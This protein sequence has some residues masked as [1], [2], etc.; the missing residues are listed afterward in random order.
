[1]ANDQEEINLP[2]DNNNDRKTSLDLL[3]KYFRT[4]ANKKFL[5]ATLD[6]LIQDGVID[7]VN[8]YLGRKTAKAF[9]PSDNYISDITDDRQNYQLEPA[10]VVKDNNNNTTFYKDYNDYINQLTAFGANTK[11]H[12]RLN[13]QE[14]YSWDP[15]V[16]WDKLTNYREYYWLS[17]GPVTISISGQEKGITSTYTVQL[18]NDGDSN[19]YVFNPDGLTRNPTL[20]LYRGQTYNFEIDQENNPFFIKTKKTKTGFEYNEKVTN[21]GIEKGTVSIT[22]DQNT[23]DILYY[24]NTN[25]M[26]ATGVI[27]VLSI[28]ENTKIDVTQEIIGKKTYQLKSG[29]YLSNGMKVDFLGDV[30]PEIYA[31]GNWYVE[32]VGKEIILV[33]EQEL[34]TRFPNQ[35][36]EELQFDDVGFDTT[37]FDQSSEKDK[38]YITINRSAYD[39]NQWSRSNRWFHKEV[40][41]TSFEI[42]GLSPVIDQSARANRPIIEFVPGL[43]LFNNGWNRIGDV[44]LVDTV[45]TNIMSEI[46]GTTGYYIDNINLVEG[47]RIIFTA[48]D[49]LLVR[50]KIYKV[51]F[52][53]FNNERIITLIP[54]ETVASEGD[55]VVVKTGKTNQGKQF[56]YSDN[57]WKESQ[58][59]TTENQPPMFDLYDNDGISL[60]DGTVYGSTEFAGNTVFS[61]RQGNGT[62]DSVLGFPITYLNVSNIGDIVFDCNLLTDTYSYIINER[63]FSIIAKDA[64][65]KVWNRVGNFGYHSAWERAIE[66]STQPVIRHY[67]ADLTR[68]NFEI[69]VYNNAA[70]LSDLSVQVFLNNKI[71]YD[72]QLEKIDTRLYLN[73]TQ[74]LQENDSLI[75]KTHTK[76][77]N[78]TSKGYYE[79]PLNLQNNPTNKDPE[80]ITLGEIIDHVESIVNDNPDVTGN[81]PGVTNLRD[82]GTASKYGKRFV[83]HSGPV[84]IALYHL[85]NKSTNIIKAL[86][87]AAKDYD[88]F[89][90]SYI[91]YITNNSVDS[92][93]PVAVD[94]VLLELLNGKSEI[95]YNSG[96]VP[97]RAFTEIEHTIIDNTFELY[98]IT[99]A[100][101]PYLHQDKAILVYINDEQ[102][103]FEKDYEFINDN[104]VKITKEKQPGDKIVIREYDTVVGSYIPPTPAKLGLLPKYRPMKYL[105]TTLQTPVNVIQ[106]HDGSVIRAFD[107]YRDDLILELERRIYNNIK[108]EYTNDLIDF[109]DFNPSAYRQTDY[110]LKEVNDILRPLFLKWHKN[111]NVS[112]N[113]NSWF[114]TGNPWTYNYSTGNYNG[115]DL[116]G[117]WRG[118]YNHW[119]DTDRPHISPWEMLGFSTEPTW[120]QDTYGPAPYTSENLILWRDLE[121]GRIKEPGAERINNKFKRPGLTSVIPVDQNGNLKDPIATNIAQEYDTLSFTNDFIFGDYAPVENAWRR[122]SGYRFSLLCA[123]FLTKPAQVFGVYLDRAHTNRDVSGIIKY[124]GEFAT[125][126]GLSDKVSNTML[127]SGLIDYVNNWLYQSGSSFIDE[128]IFNLE[129][130]SNQLGAKL[131]G[132][133]EKQKFRLILDSRTPLNEGNV[134]VPDENYEVILNTSSPVEVLSYSGVIIEKQSN[135]FIIKGYDQKFPFF[136]YRPVITSN[137][138]T[139]I[140]IGAVSESFIS[141]AEEKTYIQGKIVNYNGLYYRCKED[142]TSTTTFDATKFVKLTELPTIGG[143]KFF[144]RSSYD[145]DYATLDYGTTLKTVQDV[146]DFLYGYSKY[147]EDAGF[148]FDEYDNENQILQDWDTSVKEFVFWTTQ[149]WA[150]GTVIALSPGAGKFSVNIEYTNV[151]DLLNDFYDYEIYNSSGTRININDL[152]VSRANSKFSLSSNAE[153]GIYFARMHLVQTEHVLLID[154]KTVF[155]DIIYDTPAGY[156]QERVKVLGYKT[157]LWDG[158]L[159]TPGFVYD[160]IVINN[161]EPF[162]QYQVGDIVKNKE[163]LYSAKKKVVS[164]EYFD[165]SN[166][167]QL[168]GVQKSQL[169]PNFDYRAEQFTDFFDLDTDN[170]DSEQQ[171][172]AQHTIGYQKRRYLENIINDDVSQYKFYQGMI[173]DKGTKNV[174]NKMFD[175]LSSA[176]QESLEFYEEWAIRV[177]QYGAVDSFVEVEYLIDEKNVRLDPQ[178][179]E[180]VELKDSSATDLVYRYTNDEAYVTYDGYTNTPF[181]A[182]TKLPDFIRTAGNVDESDVT[183]GV[184]EVDDILKLNIDDFKVGSTVWVS[185]YGT[186]WN[187][188]RMQESGANVLAINPVGKDVNVT[189]NN[190]I[191]IS[192]GDIVAIKNVSDEA[193][194]FY[195]I[196]AI[197]GYTVTLETDKKLDNAI[198]M[199]DSSLGIFYNFVDARIKDVGELNNITP[200]A[201]FEDGELIWVDG[202]DGNWTVYEKNKVYNTTELLNRTQ[203]STSGTFGKSLAVDEYNRDFI[204]G[205]PSLIVSAPVPVIINGVIEK[206]ESKSE[207]A[208]YV[209][210][211][212]NDITD[213]RLIQTITLPD[214]L[215]VIE[216]DIGL[217]ALLERPLFTGFGQVISTS[218]DTRFM[219]VGVPNASDIPSDFLGTWSAITVYSSDDVVEYNGAFYKA[220]EDGLFATTPDLVDDWVRVGYNPI[221]GQAISSSGL[222]DQGFVSVYVRT[223]SGNFTNLF[224]MQSPEPQAGQRFGETIRIEKV[225]SNDYRMFVAAPNHDGIGKIFVFDWNLGTGGAWTYNPS[226]NLPA[227]VRSTGAERI[228]V[229]STNM[230]YG[231]AIN[232][233]NLGNTLLVSAPY[234]NGVHFEDY[235]GNYDAAV[236]YAVDSVVFYNSNYWKKLTTSAAGTTPVAGAD[237]SQ[238]T[239]D[240]QGQYGKLYVYSYTNSTYNLVEVISEVNLNNANP[241]SGDKFAHSVDVTTDGSTLA[242]G[243]PNYDG[244]GNDSGKVLVLAYNGTSYE[245]EQ[246]LTGNAVDNQEFGYKVSISGDTLAIGSRR[247]DQIDR[248]TILPEGTTFDSDATYLS[249]IYVDTGK[250]DVYSK[251][252]NVFTYEDT[253]ILADRDLY[254]LGSVLIANRNHVIVGVPNYNDYA[255]GVIDFW[256]P[257]NVSSWKVHRQAVYP[258]DVT[259]VKS[260]FLYD[261]RKNV[262]VKQLDVIDPLQGKIA[263]PADQE[264]DYKTFWD[265]AI[266][267]VGTEEVNVD[268]TESWDATSVGKVWWDLDTARF[269]NYHQNSALYRANNWSKLSEY[270]DIDV[271]EWVSSKYKPSQWDSLADSDNGLSLGVSGKT[272]YGDNAY[273]VAKEYD[274]V[275]KNFTSKYMFWVKQKTTVPAVENRKLSVAAIS[276]L[277]ANPSSQGYAHI[278]I[279]SDNSFVLY[280]CKQFLNDNDIA[281]NIRFWNTD[282]IDS[283]IHKQYQIL[284]EG[285]GISTPNDTIINKWFDSL[286]GFTPEGLVVPNPNLSEQQRYGILNKPRQG[287]FKN[288]AEAFKQFIEYVNYVFNK[289]ILVDDFDLAPFF[290]KEQ[291]PNE[292]SRLYDLQ[293]EDDL[294]LNFIATGKLQPAAID[295][296]IEDGRV[297]D[298]IITDAGRGYIT[299]PLI[300]VVGQGS[301]AVLEANLDAFGRISTVDIKTSG[302]GYLDDTYASVRQYTVLSTNVNNSGNWGLYNY[303]TASKTWQ[304]I[305]MQSYDVSKYWTYKDW[306]A[307]GFNESTPIDYL[308]EG[309]FQL[310]NISPRTN[311]LVKITN[312]GSSGEW[313]LL[314]RNNQSNE[315]DINLN[316][317]VVG[318]QSATIEISSALYNFNENVLGYDGISYEEIPYDSIP[319]TEA[320]IILEAIRSNVFIDNLKVEFN[321]LFFNSIRY[322]LTEQLSV[323][324]IFKT[325]FV[326]AKHNVGEL[327]QRVTY[328]N[329]SLSSYQDYVNEVKP[330]RTKVRE[331][332]SS[333]TKTETVNTLTSDFDLRAN[334]N[335]KVIDNQLLLDNTTTLDVYPDKSWKDN[336]SYGVT[337]IAIQDAGLGYQTAPELTIIGG[338]GTGATARAFIGRGGSLSTIQITNPGTGYYSAPQIIING[339][340]DDTGRAATLVA[341]IDNGTTRKNK[342]TVK[343]DRI[344]GTTELTTLDVTETFIGTGL[345]TDFNLK[346]PVDVRKGFTTVTVN[347]VEL[348]ES[349]FTV[350][351]VT[352]YNDFTSKAGHL[353]IISPPDATQ[354][355]VVEYKKDIEFLR[356]SDRINYYYNPVSGQRSS[357]LSGLLTGI[358]YGGTS[359]T[360]F[361]FEP[362]GGWGTDGTSWDQVNWEGN[363]ASFTDITLYSS[364]ADLTYTFEEAPAESETWNVYLNGVRIDDPNFGTPAEVANS[365]AIMQSIIGDGTATDFVIPVSLAPSLILGGS[366]QEQII[367]RRIDSDGSFI[368][369]GVEIDSVVD[370]QDLGYTQA[371][372]YNPEDIT[373]DGDGFVT[374]TTNGGLEEQLSGHVSEAIDMYVYNLAKS[375]GPQINSISYVADGST[376][377]FAY[378]ADPQSEDALIIKVNDE[379]LRPTEYKYTPNFAAYTDFLTAYDSNKTIKEARLAELAPLISD[380]TTDIQTLNS[381]L[382]D[383]LQEITDADALIVAYQNDVTFYEF[384]IVRINNEISALDPESP[385]YAQQLGVLQSELSG[386]TSSLSQSQAL[387]TDAQDDKDTAVASRDAISADIVTKQLILD[388]YE[389]EEVQLEADVAALNI[390][391]QTV[392]DYLINPGKT[393]I[394]NNT[395]NANDV[396]TIISFGTNGNDI[397][398]I[399]EFTGDGSTSEFVTPIKYTDQLRVF[400]TVNGRQQTP[401]T[402]EATELYDEAG[403]LILDF[404]PTP[405]ANATVKYTVYNNDAPD[406]SYI[407][408]QSITTDSSTL[409]YSLNDTPY[410]ASPSANFVIAFKGDKL[411]NG[412]Y[413]QTSIATTSNNYQVDLSDF[414]DGE[415]S[416]DHTEVYVDGE[417]KQLGVDYQIDFGQNEVQFI[418]GKIRPGQEIKIFIMTRA[419]YYVMNNQFVLAS[420]PDDGEDIMIMTFFNTDVFDTNH[421]SKSVLSR[422]VLTPDSKWYRSSVAGNA[423]IILLDTAISNENYVMIA[424]NGSILTPHRDYR[425]IEN[426]T[427]VQVDIARNINSTDQFYVIVFDYDPV[428][429]SIA[430]RQF[431]DNLNRTHY[432]AINNAKSTKLVT[433]LN[434]Y[435]MQIEVEDASVLD[436]P[437]ARRNVPGIVFIGSER[438]EYMQKTGN[439]LSQLRRGTVGTATS[440]AYHVGAEVL[441]QGSSLTIDYA[442][443]E[444][445][446]I[447]YGDGT[448]QEFLLPY[449]VTVNTST[450][451]ANNDWNRIHETDSSVLPVPDVNGQ[452]EDIE[453]F[454]GGK[455]MLKTPCTLYNPDKNQ[456]SPLADSVLPADFSAQVPQLDQDGNKIPVP[457]RFTVPPALGAKIIIKRKQGVLWQDR[458]ESLA[459]A[460]NSIA[461]FL[462]AQEV[463][464]PK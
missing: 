265:P 61:Y 233:A 88:K 354:T 262:L 388:D 449:A 75:I 117:Y 346:W 231:H 37:P 191:D 111:L 64:Y 395:P 112:Y 189:L 152:D 288:K 9:L 168:S 50:D 413:T 96:M 178:P 259:K 445:T 225:G 260:A 194:K 119:Y 425:L 401:R 62:N 159:T 160:E 1:M 36:L 100:Y 14:Y 94:N 99:E 102:L 77:A 372:G 320:R 438:I 223:G 116:P 271:Y 87:N 237:W 24:T 306:Y 329:D 252:N 362:S 217:D 27:Q 246:T 171:R 347:G 376:K 31:T 280:N 263:G 28:D 464:F 348:L 234:A 254:D 279:T 89:Q 383:I 236:A 202:V 97:F 203:S 402:K 38:D 276:S 441:N 351:N 121:A 216:Y 447:F 451:R 219:A 308:I 258:A 207:S 107:D 86:D 407:Q 322:I 32:G 153:D 139:Q 334:N 127:A 428:E 133:T 462:R 385:T 175:K 368:P 398:L 183:F 23:P 146:V 369:V 341:I 242:I 228:E 11:N 74:D 300:T 257:N 147:L 132:Y 283:N 16:D 453:V 49:D 367:L 187:I 358:D 222:D 403:R 307:S 68:N 342:L 205:D 39:G 59:K 13:A 140:S 431:T 393:I 450:T 70:T 224:N 177:G 319:I 184:K 328:K 83:K 297:V 186:T 386:V 400:A 115:T 250:V 128:Y 192:I 108:I 103:V 101:N 45:T 333:Y 330:Y 169:L 377:S 230:K 365:N 411:L 212:S 247:G 161:W 239:V 318:R 426:G 404:D 65:L 312:V 359:I 337:S 56:W 335:I 72:Y 324:W 42:S 154:N 43:Q 285:L 118:I 145:Q 163:F 331:F 345:Q 92:T 80:L 226:K 344:T 315:T 361:G 270:A 442:D 55:T 162:K 73:F 296:R 452:V 136:T 256:K 375:G 299:P 141:W 305:R 422:R 268:E 29:H 373:L 2:G 366:N 124:A 44:D 424:I 290:D 155:N 415:F 21:N 355:V 301:G 197:N 174:L 57:R 310:A 289:T 210:A 138:D 374:P 193:D 109:F 227:A 135:G 143:N 444:I 125:L 286:V 273:A 26:S 389:A 91:D 325:S 363:D 439:I 291:L 10:L 332:I 126:S 211:R 245:L 436:T 321:N 435:D 71:V 459:D 156:R 148:I 261:T 4:D 40:I 206:Y 54:E 51:K 181:K 378:I 427:A 275:S 25:D 323:D 53:R 35:T 387:L 457:L 281:L 364:Q 164:A 90:K 440:E 218:P 84:N 414:A 46:E 199:E 232:T 150:A 130:A 353:E 298:V 455:R 417:L 144:Y 284:T 190:N 416:S 98:G 360:G 142:H 458:G 60:S 79:F 418:A 47:M 264:I 446:S 350:G 381:S 302:S 188:L 432:K 7:K 433:Q 421:R 463:S 229:T 390:D 423:G 241:T 371:T 195:K 394:L 93:V 151:D 182:T 410:G 67:I 69:D 266:Y 66:N 95:W 58:Q 76:L 78:K 448:T 454:V 52:V 172:L 253:I 292:F 166:W 17:Q 370:G 429:K 278:A 214:N 380:I 110:N 165:K 48:D 19:A 249:D 405:E 317:E 235:R 274:P 460:D 314:K 81:F 303:S 343:F 201:G 255:G 357:D 12:S 104:F 129:N 158:G 196:K 33:S 30:T 179:F 134:F 149:N 282:N 408:R 392:G 316:Y 340:V 326:K 113:E 379:I 122:S 137:S 437:N 157:V 349:E 406:Y 412:G 434:W 131:A 456:T 352:T 304:I 15:R 167:T 6:P 461:S 295:L 208:I 382:D 85:T 185:F 311:Q 238:Q 272:K 244:N 114:E 120:W 221:D 384:E 293:I 180:L 18:V 243:V 209:Y 20:K 356:A 170:F 313:L 8:G 338:G 22:V 106:G 443:T 409:A 430:F 336:H 200:V 397:I 215:N 173:L 294:E 248:L 176:D 82:I 5:S 267:T 198:D 339:S 309:S 213:H 269:T 327:T 240:S 123:W 420:N 105:D 287:M 34:E 63:K 251:Y 396:V 220:A 399:D 41:E 419:D 277:I 391:I 204:V 3:P